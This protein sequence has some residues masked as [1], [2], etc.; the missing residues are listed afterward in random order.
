MTSKPVCQE[1]TEADTVTMWH[2]TFHDCNYIS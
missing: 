1:L 2:R